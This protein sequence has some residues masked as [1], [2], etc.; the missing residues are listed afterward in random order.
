MEA[1]VPLQSP[2]GN[3]S[4][5]IDCTESRKPEMLEE[6]LMLMAPALREGVKVWRGRSIETVIKT[7]CWHC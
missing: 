7:G 6:K 1:A 5:L 4:R 3:C 2:K